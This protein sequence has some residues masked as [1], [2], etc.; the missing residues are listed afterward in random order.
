[1]T[2][3]IKQFG[4]DGLELQSE[5]SLLKNKAYWEVELNPFF[6][7]ESKGYFVIKRAQNFS[8]PTPANK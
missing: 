6:V 1:M 5:G 7:L 3:V 4:G 8:A 2:R